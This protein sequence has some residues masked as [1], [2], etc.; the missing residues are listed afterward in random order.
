MKFPVYIVG[1]GPGDPDLI[2]LKA[3]RLLGEYA[4]VVVYDRLIPDSILKFIPKNVEKVYAGKSCRKHVMTQT[5]INEELVRQAKRGKKVVRL[6]GGDPFIFGRGGEEI[7]YLAQ[8]KI[9][10]EVVPGISAIAGISSYLGIPLTH[11]GLASGVRYIT[12]HQQKGKPVEHDWKGL[13]DKNTTLV[14]YMALANLSNITDELI[15]HGMNAKTPAIAIQEGTMKTE[16]VCLATLATIA[17]K[18][19]KLGFEPPTIIIIGK[20]VGLAKKLGTL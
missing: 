14:L 2:T 13:A 8:N 16:R 5:E 12:G 17:K 10:F 20:V 7:E 6:K 19:K 4:E 15:K 11:R 1:A 18:T 3:H 9:P